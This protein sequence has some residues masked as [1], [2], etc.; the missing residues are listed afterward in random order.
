MTRA[1]TCSCGGTSF[2]TSTVGYTKLA[3][4]IL[5]TCVNIRFKGRCTSCGTT[6][7]E[8]VARNVPADTDP[9]TYWKQH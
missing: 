4:G 5:T 2:L 9:L 8:I 3:A 1:T 6:H 7:S